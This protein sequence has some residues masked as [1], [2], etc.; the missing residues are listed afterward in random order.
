MDDLTA[1]SHHESHTSISPF[2]GLTGGDI[3]SCQ[4]VALGCNMSPLQGLIGGDNPGSWIVS[5]FQGLAGGVISS[6]QAVAKR[7][8]QQCSLQR[9]MNSGKRSGLTR[10]EKATRF[11]FRARH[12]LFGVFTSSFIVHRSSFAS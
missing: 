12:L 7:A 4:G 8:I 6:S 1:I 3:R 11:A 5:P 9:L 10:I 2:Q